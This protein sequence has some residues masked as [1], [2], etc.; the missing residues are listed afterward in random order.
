M[1]SSV[2]SSRSDSMN[3]CVNGHVLAADGAGPVVVLSSS[4]S[5]MSSIVKPMSHEA[6]IDA[7]KSTISDTCFTVN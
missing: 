5:S 1:D 3:E 4:S 2:S 6:E 7:E